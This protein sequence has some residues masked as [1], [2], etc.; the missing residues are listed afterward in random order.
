M[1]LFT[2]IIL[3]WL[4]TI[5]RAR[6]FSFFAKIDSPP[7]KPDDMLFI[8]TVLKPSKVRCTSLQTHEI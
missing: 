1:T 2:T 5:M 6:K 4:Q 8:A 7:Q 3:T